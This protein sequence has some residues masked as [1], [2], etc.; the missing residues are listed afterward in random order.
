MS[1][2][3]WLLLLIALVLLAAAVLRLLW[4]PLQ[5]RAAAAE[6][7]APL[8]NSQV[9][10]PAATPLQINDPAPTLQSLYRLAFLGSDMGAETATQKADKAELLNA[11]AQLLTRIETR[12]EYA[13][14]R[15]QL[16]PQLLTTLNRDESSLRQLAQLVGRDPA[17]S[18]N[19]LRLVN[20]ALYRNQPQAIE[21]LERAV[22]LLGT[23]G[24]RSIVAAA[25]LQPELG[26]GQGTWAQLPALVWDLSLHSALAA[27]S[28]AVL[29]EDTD[30]FAA[31]LL[32]LLQGLGA[33]IVVRVCRDQYALRP[34]LQPDFDTVH[35]LLEAWAVP[36]A[37]RVG[38]TWELSDRISAALHDQLMQ[39]GADT[40]TPLG[41][42]LRFGLQA[43]AAAVLQRKGQV[44]AEQ[45]RALLGDASDKRLDGIWERLIRDRRR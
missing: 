37:R 6:P 38:E 34:Q 41:R 8:A 23:K 29:I 33:I 31:E 27:A 25:L 3:Q 2:L 22:T 35:A 40:L 28:Y 24:L 13:P 4:G 11:A 43:G 17:L 12:P 16:L 42:A 1:I 30:P 5:P 26:E 21:S 45:G 20:S 36:T 39:T 44:D 18:G 10:S 19:V 32:G 14:R 15:P 7:A 9:S